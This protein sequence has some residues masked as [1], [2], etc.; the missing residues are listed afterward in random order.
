[1]NYKITL[2][3]LFAI[4]RNRTSIPMAILFSF[5]L[6]IVTSASAQTLKTDSNIPLLSVCG[7]YQQLTVRIAKG[8][9]ACSQGKLKIEI[10]VGF[11]LQL[12]SVKANGNTVTVTGETN[13]GTTVTLPNITA[14][15]SSE[16]MV[17][18]YNVKALC[19]V[20]GSI[21]PAD[22]QVVSYVFSGCTTNPQS[23][24][25]EIINIDFAV[26][27]VTVN[28]AVSSGNVGDEIS[29]TVTIRNQGNGAISTVVLE[30][31]L[32]GGLNHVS[33]DF[34]SALGWTADATNPN[35][36]TFSGSSLDTGGTISFK[37]KVKINSCSLTPTIY[38]VYYGCG[39][40]CTNSSV[41]GTAQHIININNSFKPVIEVSAIPPVITCLNQSYTNTWN[42]KNSGNAEASS[43]GLEI[44]T[45]DANGYININTVTVGG[46]AVNPADI[47]I[48]QGT[49]AKPTLIKVKI[50]ADN[51]LDPNQVVVVKFDQYYAAPDAA[52]CETAPTTF[53]TN[54]NYYKVAYDFTGGCGGPY[55][56]SKTVSPAVTYNY[57]GLNIG[58]IDIVSGQSYGADYL[59]TNFVIPHA[60]LNVGDKFEITIELSELLTVANINDIKLFT[61]ATAINAVSSADGANKYRLTFTYGT[62]PWTVGNDLNLSNSRLKFPIDF[63][64]GPDTNTGEVQDVW[65]KIGGEL[66]KTPACDA[67][68]F[69]CNQVNLLGYCDAG[70]CADGLHNRSADLERT[71]LGF[72]VTAAGVPMN[73]RVNKNDTNVRTFIT[74]DILEI[75]QDSDVIITTPG[76]WTKVKFQVEK[77][78]D[79][80]V[81]LITNSGKLVVT[82]AATET[83]FDVLTVVEN[84]TNYVLEFDLLT[85]PNALTVFL[86]GDKVRFSMKFKA[87][88]SQV[89][90]KRFPTK[91]YL[92]DSNGVEKICGRAYTATGFYVNNTVE[93]KGSKT[94]FATCSNSDNKFVITSS[95][96]GF[97]RQ[98][99][100]FEG[101]F[102]DLLEPTKAVL[103]VPAFL[104]LTGA[105]VEVKNQ[106]WLGINNTAIITGLNVN[107]GTYI[108]DL[109]TIISALTANK[110][111]DEGFVIEI[112]PTVSL[113]ECEPS[114]TALVQTI[115]VTLEGD[116]VDGAGD[117]TPFSKTQQLDYNTGFGSLTLELSNNNL[118]GE[119]SPDGQ[120]VSWIVKVA[121][122]SNS[123]SFP[124]VWLGKK[125]GNLVIE[126][127]QK[128][129]NYDGSNPLVAIVPTGDVYQLGDFAASTTNF[130]LVKANL[131]NC[132]VESLT[133]PIGYSCTAY[134]VNV[135]SGVCVVT[136]KV[137]TYGQLK[138]NLQ[139]T[140]AF[141][142]NA[143]TQHG[144]CDVLSYTVQIHNAGDTNVKN[145]SVRIPLASAPGLKYNGS[146]EYSTVFSG[147]ITPSVVFSNGNPAS[148]VISGTDLIITLDNSISLNT[149]ERVQLKVNFKIETCEFKSGQRISF[150]PSAVNICGSPLPGGSITSASGNRIIVAGGSTAFPELVLDLN[151]VVLD[152]VIDLGGNLR[153][154]YNFSTTNSGNFG[155]TDAITTDY[156][157]AFKFPANWVI[158]GNPSDY[159]VPA[160]AAVFEGI[161]PVRGYIFKVVR[162]L[163]VGTVVKL[164]DVPLKYTAHD[165]T[166]LSCEHYFGDVQISV[167]Q[168]IAVPTCINPN[169]NCPNG[170][171]QVLLED[172]IRMV[173][174][175]DNMLMINPPQQTREICSPLVGGGQPTLAD[176][177]FS[178]GY[179]LSWYENELDA[180][181]EVTPLPLTTP[182]I[183]NR[184]YY[185]VNRFIAGGLCK[186][187]L[188]AIKVLL[189][190][191]NLQATNIE[192]ACA[193]DQ[194]SYKVFVTLNGTAPYTAVGTG[195]GAE[196][197]F[198]G[199]IWTSESIPIGTPYDVTFENASMCTP[200]T[201]TGIPPVCCTLQIAC[202]VDVEVVCGTSYDPS[203]TGI[204]TAITACGNITQT[205]TD[206]AITACVGG[207][208]TFTRTFT[209]TDGSGN[210]ETCTQRISIKDVVAP[211]LDVPAKNLTVECGTNTTE[212]LNNWLSSHGGAI[213]TDACGAVTWTHNFTALTA[214]LC[215]GTQSATVIFTATDACGNRVTS[216]AKFTI[217]DKTPPV[218]S[219][220]AANKTVECD[221]TGNTAAL[222]DWLASHGGAVATDGCSVTPVT[223]THN[224]T[225]LTAGTCAGS[226]NAVVTFTATDAC[227]NKSTTTATFAIVDTTAPVI[228]VAPQNK[229]V[230]CDGLGN[231]DEFN[232][233]LRISGGAVA[234]DGCGAVTW[235]YLIEDTN[236]T[237]GKAGTVIVDFFAKDSCGNTAFK[238][239]AFIIVD[240]T[241]PIISTP[242]K[243]LNIECGAEVD[244][245]NAWLNN[246]GGAISSDNC[247]TI[248]WT[249]NYNG[250]TA[251]CG[252]TG[253]AVVTFKAT[254]SC[255]NFSETVATVTIADK[256]PPV[257][258]KQAQNLTVACG[259]NAEQTLNNWLLNRGGAEATDN[260]GT[261]TWTHNYVELTTRT[262]GVTGF[263]LVTFTA[264]DACGNTATTT[265]TYKVEDTTAPVITHP[266]ENKIVECDGTNYRTAMNLWLLSHGRATVAQACSDVTWTHNFTA[267][268]AGETGSAE[269]TFTATDACGNWVSTTATYTVVDR[270]AP[271]ITVLPQNKTVECD[272]NGNLD[273]FNDW[274]AIHAG[275][276][277]TDNCGD[278]TWSYLIEDTNTTCG[279]AGT[280]IVDFIVKDAFGNSTFKQAAFI[281]KDTTKPVVSTVAKDLIIQ[282]GA[283]VDALNAWLNN[284]GGAVASDNCG[285]IT[286]THNY[287]GLTAACGNTGSAVVTFTATDSCGNFSETVATISLVDTVAPTLVK[288][289][290]DLTVTCGANTAEALNNWLIS[291]AGAIAK[292]ACGAVTWTHNYT[293]LTTTACGTTG[294]ALVTFTAT[295]ACGN[296]VTTSATYT[297]E[298]KAV[299]V[300]TRAAQ[301]KTVECDGS[302]NET[303]LNAWLA[304]QGGATATD[305]CSAVTW[306]NDY[307]AL[308]AACGATGSALVTFTATDACGNTVT[309]TA[310]FTIADTKAPIMTTV[311][312]N[313]VVE[314]DGAG[315]T[316]A[317]DTWLNS[318]AGAIASDACSTTVTW[319][320]SIVD[321]S[322]LCGKTKVITVN[323]VATD[324]CGNAVTK[325]ATFTIADTAGPVLTTA[326]TDLIMECG[327]SGNDRINTWL[328]SHG[329]ASATEACGSV[330]WSH[331]YTGL[332][333]ACGAT[334]NA[335]VTFT[336][337]DSCGNT[338]VTVANISIVDTVAPTLVKAAQGLTVSCGTNTTE[339]L[340][341]WLSSHGGA[342][343][344]DT[345]SSVTWTNNY[346]ALTAAC[347]ATGSALVTFTATDACGN[348]VTTAATF[349]IEDKTAP[350][351]TRAAQ[352]KTVE[353]DGSGNATELNAWLAI[354]GGATATDSCSAVTW[355]NDF[356]ALTAACGATGSALVTFTATDACGN[357]VTTTATFTI[358]DTKAPIITTAP[359]N[360]VVECDGAG[361]LTEFNAWLANQGAA[362]A[363]D[364]CSG[365]TWTYAIVD[366]IKLCGKTQAITVNFTATDACG[367]SAMKQATF[368]TV[369]TTGPQFVVE[370]Q[371]LTVNCDGNGN[372]N[373][374]MAWLNTHGGAN[375]VN[376]CSLD[377]TWTNDFKGLTK[378]CGSTGS[379]VVTFKVTDSCGNVSAT[380]ATFTIV[381]DIAPVFTTNLPKDIT[382]ECSALLPEAAV[383]NATDLC[384]TAEV[385]FKEERLNGNCEN[386]Y[387]L[388]RTW[389]ATDACGNAQVHVQTITI[390]DTTAP[391]FVEPLPAADVFMKCEDLKAAPVMTATDACGK[392]TVAFKEEKVQG[393]CDNKYSLE[394]TWTATDTC[395][396]ETVYTQTVHLAC[397]IEIYNAISANGDGN[398]DEFV[399]KGI[400]C[401]PGN[402]V[403]IFDRWGRLVYS[404]RNYNSIGNV[405][406][407]YANAKDVVSKGDK[408]PTGTYFYVVQY[409]YNFGNGE[410]Q[411]MK[412]SG[413]IHLESN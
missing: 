229:T 164:V 77:D 178:N 221:G 219:I 281:I 249:H 177:T 376:A 362:V 365:V 228:T 146:F 300:I 75:H 386:N 109:N 280:I 17:I 19:S 66:I 246:H 355:T 395:G 289:G 254:D 67:I 241:K 288:A 405:F 142:S 239:A 156:R 396:N 294:S 297:V 197:R 411:A 251:A 257:I 88:D 238:Q 54:D 340:N 12:G 377:M 233:W 349:T 373:D 354:Q 106:P 34:S 13:Q 368:T 322:N 398:N 339:A 295:D 236:T 298:D 258:T 62:A 286:W 408:L 369:N 190:T 70:P 18:T 108:L 200:L 166:T 87:L 186:S 303:E 60:G 335:V 209:V 323:F 248:T 161:D 394:R 283:E 27:R 381:D 400:N 324:A 194:R 311:P 165:D 71:T 69:K 409:D 391:V 103:T 114:A 264:T 296:T 260:C 413:Y 255:G 24:T 79:T 192:F 63:L 113:F 367:N 356:S 168:N 207:L 55:T 58:E 330:T 45:N 167:Y 85:Q 28:P 145:L 120:L 82:R 147:N 275:A 86:Q 179:Y 203:V 47:E 223:W 284:H 151:E 271:V 308:T 242:A 91:S 211:V 309:T 8:S 334:G 83:E 256:T 112:T 174:P 92:I 89:G 214:G 385:S 276:V 371:D 213:A 52:S 163:P 111:L 117:K 327:T 134:P 215:A 121:N 206:S 23:G 350:V 261:V 33:Y 100:V 4:F 9:R 105:K 392:A 379:T 116:V 342:R 291:H 32:G 20:I 21:V 173:L 73:T 253:S 199:N 341:N 6:L 196:S 44:G 382:L 352:N 139:T 64:C 328:N 169:L 48:L 268:S 273:E 193:P 332:T 74:G 3:Q 131:I 162:N 383:L 160:G 234:K 380:T 102:R 187:N 319:S 208:R 141:Q 76:A 129:D 201:I 149:L 237:C 231:L 98:D 301:N 293:G 143:N 259:P 65:Y 225:V 312:Q 153:A 127:V 29:R 10:P 226:Q 344:T 406:K 390:Q 357:T 270:T 358:V 218:I 59:F 240:T 61:G 175:I 307:T 305:S 191:N 133:I 351:I 336:A 90:L 123:R 250:L 310:T 189:K 224:F 51:T 348:T 245:L 317:F 137:L 407:G 97:S 346:T 11:E 95:I 290:Q 205:Y 14:G 104:T 285:T 101:E 359:Q 278:V 39:T 222:N 122:T 185:V 345:C 374:L 42:V 410:S 243:A 31:I 202:P 35:K 375:A 329:G 183:H 78:A 387:Q 119:M 338:T 118:N 184:T 412:Q 269:V 46:V 287:N 99:G 132:S 30:R 124:N 230:E 1:M 171:D 252:N 282:C 316:A 50:S 304:I 210:V 135:N 363:T 84:P 366:T 212:A 148:A 81:A 272:G 313:A 170:I 157:F 180:Q 277:A 22:Q 361:N 38:E 404:T 68:V 306:T 262:C 53:T 195:V 235:S 125:A 15:P 2:I 80:N 378:A 181:A 198:D 138:N 244:A 343:A 40:K 96:L 204:P 388:V 43:V 128:V 172:Q 337:T 393:D 267:L 318:H 331:N 37:E 220:V 326:A 130:Y 360:A 140:I 158:V 107:N 403:E 364:A 265:A 41:S 353:C 263:A 216:T 57:E 159:L 150:V 302:G 5:M 247:G 217:E 370:A 176:I 154:K 347:G 16:E 155:N 25:S 136:D 401:Y 389:T 227:G 292:D 274:L 7:D 314:C 115:G 126:S 36:I 321:T 72:A 152:P 333:A 279:K 94:D 188:A 93:V 144:F 299:P 399:L 325:Q 402:T 182:L 315:N 384:G 110:N 232:E 26:L 49:A 266:A 372:A 320:H 56:D 397:E